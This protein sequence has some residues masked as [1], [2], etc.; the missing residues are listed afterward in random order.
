MFRSRRLLPAALCVLGLGLPAARAQSSFLGKPL[1]VWRNELASRDSGVRR[2]AAFALGRMGGEA[3]QAAPDLVARLQK[4]T[5]AGV[6][7]M[8][9]TALGD[10]AASSP[11]GGLD[12]WD[13]AGAALEKAL[14]DP[15]P[16]VRRSAA[17]ALGSFGS[18]AAPAAAALKRALRDRDS[19][20]VRQNAAWALGRL[21]DPAGAA[22]VDPLCDLLRDDDAL[23]RRDAA[24]AL[25]ALGRSAA[26]RGVSPDAEGPAGQPG[27]PGGS[28]AQKAVSPLLALVKV[29]RDEVVRKTALDAL[30]H[31]AGP[32]HR[33]SAGTLYPMLDSQDPEE[34]RA[35]ALI[36]GRMGGAPA[37]KALPVLRR[38]L[39]DEDPEL[40]ALAAASLANVGPAA[41]DAVPDL[42]RALGRDRD[43]TVRR[44]AALAL[45]HIGDVLG[46]GVP[47]KVKEAVPALV[48]ALRLSEP[49]VIRQYAAQTLS[50]IRY[51]ANEAAVPALLVA[52]RK[53]TE[54][55]V[56][57]F[58]IHALF[59][60]P[61]I[62]RIKADQVLAAVLDETSPD[63][64]F[65]LARYTA[66][67]LLAVSLHERAP[68][69]TADVLLHM[70]NNKGLLI[71][72]GT[73]A[74][75]AGAGNESS[76]GQSDVRDSLGGDA[77]YLAAEALG[78]LRAKAAKR[79]D[80][81]SALREAARDKDDMLREE[82]K[83]ALKDLGLAP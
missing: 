62:E 66:A 40:Q 1:K 58:C 14:S 5:D 79:P 54:P 59:H 47:D 39:Q 27:A 53:D 26:P 2:S 77:R 7:D 70:L 16:R 46:G 30:A 45:G 49:A 72:N 74:S 37:K 61:D 55:R 42:A 65:Q 50:Q 8:A 9:A 3:Y 15:D 75:V 52:I 71:F 44:N 57:Q 48:G 17:Y 33:G 31:L 4:D 24:G 11:G 41:A 80:V 34:A 22:G 81:V 21:G 60:Y 29:E 12:V 82:A 10:I 63:P 25:G 83:K 64:R 35:A 19:P 69:Q 32:E 51:P 20:A 68:D 36:L 28:A 73:N 18:H 67:R 13:K 78:H 43:T 38:T 6:R 76:R 56:R 23:V